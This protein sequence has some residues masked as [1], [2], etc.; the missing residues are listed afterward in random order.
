MRKLL[1]SAFI[2][3][4]T[5]TTI[6]AQSFGIKAGVNFA[7]LSGDDA[8]GFDG[9]TSFHVGAVAELK[10]FENLSLQPELL[11]STQG[12]TIND[13]EYK[14][15]YLAL[16][17]MAKFYLND[18]L[19]VLA[20]PT[21]G[22]LVSETDDVNPNDTNTF[23]FGLAGGLEYKIVG[24]LFAHARYGVGLSEISEN[25]DIKN[26]LFQISLGYMF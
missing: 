23:D 4:G 26:S 19:S 6:N 3:L 2:L 13:D 9:L 24:G 12:A 17:V 16:P 1:L 8:D 14:L 7:N 18:K 25:S 5:I 10:V 15:N 21:F 20:G 22:V 11:F